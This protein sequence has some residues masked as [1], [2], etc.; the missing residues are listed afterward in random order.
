MLFTIDVFVVIQLKTTVER[1]PRP[2]KTAPNTLLYLDEIFNVTLWKKKK[3]A[4]L[5]YS[6]EIVGVKGE[7]FPLPPP[8]IFTAVAKLP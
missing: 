1:S 7:Q 6:E 2:L 3:F 4:L 8:R 5:D